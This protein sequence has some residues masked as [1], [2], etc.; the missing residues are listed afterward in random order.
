MIYVNDRHKSVH[1]GTLGARVCVTLSQ[2]RLDLIVKKIQEQLLLSIIK[3]RHQSIA[4]VVQMWRRTSDEGLLILIKMIT[5][6]KQI[7]MGSIP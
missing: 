5:A 6:I 1:I 2:V 3:P 7:K 4:T